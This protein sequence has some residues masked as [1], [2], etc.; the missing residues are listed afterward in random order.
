MNI[1]TGV[2][3]SVNQLYDAMAAGAG[4]SVRPD[5]ALARTGELARSALDPGR[6]EIH[7]GWKP[8]TRLADGVVEVLRHV[9]EHRPVSP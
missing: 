4:V 6:A 9:A 1:G 8:W 3:T 5:Y 2:E 7:L